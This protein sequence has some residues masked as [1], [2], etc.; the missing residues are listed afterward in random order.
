MNY[1]EE[2]I[3]TAAG[4]LTGVSKQDQYST[5]GLGL[6]GEAGEVADLIK[7]HIHHKKPLDR[8]KLLRELGDV[9]WYLEYLL[10]VCDFT[11]EQIETANIEKLRVRYPNG[12]NTE[13]S[14][15]R[16]DENQPTSSMSKDT[17]DIALIMGR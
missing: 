14:I 16:M 12:F 17:A 10:I 9:R 11:M 5:G 1:R 15:K 3:R 8:E 7:K 6:T 4:S 2:V 13:D